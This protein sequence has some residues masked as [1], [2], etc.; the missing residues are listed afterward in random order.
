MSESNIQKQIL[1]ALSEA[2]VT[3]WRNNTAVAWVG[4]ATR[5]TNGDVLLRN[6]RPLHAGL[7]K[8]SSDLIALQPV[9]ITESMLGPTIGRFVAVEVKAPKGRATPEQRNFLAHVAGRGGAAGIAR[10]P[11]EAL[12]IIEIPAKP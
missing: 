9:V 6:A 7:C 8:G 4:D 3:A 1:L 10:S 12:A 2:G 11:S 5:L